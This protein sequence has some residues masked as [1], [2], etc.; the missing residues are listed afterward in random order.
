MCERQRC[1]ASEKFSVQWL[2]GICQILDNEVC[3]GLMKRA[4]TVR[5]LKR[6]LSLLRSLA[7][8]VL[9]RLLA[10]IPLEQL[11]S[12][13]RDMANTYYSVGVKSVTGKKKDDD[14]GFFISYDD[15]DVLLSCAKE[16]CALCT[17]TT[18]EERVCPLRRVRDSVGSD[19]THERGCGYRWEV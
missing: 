10:T 5:Y 3:P 6:D 2:V 8:R 13:K 17:R 19:V 1:Y 11:K 15:Y 4:G 12:I 18:G 7:N 9:E 14:A 16:Q